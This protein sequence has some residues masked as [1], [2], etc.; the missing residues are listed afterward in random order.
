M[1]D[2]YLSSSNKMDGGQLATVDRPYHF[3]KM[4]KSMMNSASLVGASRGVKVNLDLDERIDATARL[5][6]LAQHGLPDAEIQ[7]RLFDPTIPNDGLVAGDEMRM[8]QIVSNLITNAIKFNRPGPNSHATVRTR[9]IRPS[10][11]WFEASQSTSDET[12]T[13]VTGSGSDDDEQPKPGDDYPPIVNRKENSRKW[14]AKQ[15]DSIV[16][17]VEVEDS[18]KFFFV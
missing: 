15:L 9:L 10:T 4:L 7:R 13:S 12:A 5:A 8:R 2:R 6:M 18:G 17:R 3:H 11:D 14:R 16:V 1:T